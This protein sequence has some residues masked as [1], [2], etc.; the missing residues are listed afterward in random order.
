MMSRAF[1]ASKDAAPRRPAHPKHKQKGAIEQ[2]NNERMNISTN[3]PINAGIRAARLCVCIGG[4][5][6]RGIY[7][8]CLGQANIQRS[9]LPAQGK[10]IQHDEPAMKERERG[11]S[12]GWVNGFGKGRGQSVLVLCFVD[13]IKLIFS[14]PKTTH[15]HTVL[16]GSS[17]PSA[18]ALVNFQMASIPLQ[19][20]AQADHHSFRIQALILSFMPSITACLAHN[21]QVQGVTV[22]HFVNK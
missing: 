10:K 8:S 6:R 9:M 15:A 2:A 16:T 1:V 3:K 14:F 12:T 21:I 19:K 11:S 22:L 17:V 5:Q 18:A 7:R 20:N 13:S 4:Q